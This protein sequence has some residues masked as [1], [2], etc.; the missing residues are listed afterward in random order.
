MKFTTVFIIF[1]NLK[2]SCQMFLS[3][4]VKRNVIVTSKNG[5][6]E[7][8]DELSKDVKLKKIRGIKV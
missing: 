3:Q 5:K 8:T 6:Y 4:Q 7:F 1:W 2:M